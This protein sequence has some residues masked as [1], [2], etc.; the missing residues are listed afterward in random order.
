LGE[1]YS[2]PVRFSVPTIIP[3]RSNSIHP[4]RFRRS[5]LLEAAATREVRY[6]REKR[7]IENG[8]CSDGD[9]Q[10]P[11]KRPC[12]RFAGFRGDEFGQFQPRRKKSDQRRGNLWLD[13]HGDSQR[14]KPGTQAKHGEQKKTEQLALGH[15]RRF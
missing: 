5:E 11:A 12:Q 1:W 14:K 2:P 15:H 13:G 4:P 9:A 8:I 7:V 3:H 10:K 6:Q